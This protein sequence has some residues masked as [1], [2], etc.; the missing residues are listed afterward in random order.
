MNRLKW[1]V[2]KPS[3]FL[4]SQSAELLHPEQG[5]VRRSLASPQVAGGVMAVGLLASLA[6]AVWLGY[7]FALLASWLVATLKHGVRLLFS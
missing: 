4:R 1:S 3:L 2:V 6:W 5:G 7:E